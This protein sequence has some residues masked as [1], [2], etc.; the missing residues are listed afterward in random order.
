MPT[1]HLVHR[2]VDPTTENSQS[3]ARLHANLGLGGG[4]GGSV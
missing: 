1:Q 2:V 4:G 3:I